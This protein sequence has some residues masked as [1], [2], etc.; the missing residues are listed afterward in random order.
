[1][2]MLFKHFGP[3]VTW[4]VWATFFLRYIDPLKVIWGDH[5]LWGP[6][7]LLNHLG[8][9]ENSDWFHKDFGDASGTTR[10]TMRTQR[11]CESCCMSNRTPSATSINFGLH[12]L[13]CSRE[14]HRLERWRI[15]QERVAQTNKPQ[16]FRNGWRQ[17]EFT[18]VQLQNAL[19]FPP[20]KKQ[21]E[22]YSRYLKVKGQ[23]IYVCKN[24]PENQQFVRLSSSL[25]S[26]FGDGLI[27]NT[28]WKPD[29]GSQEDF[30][31][32]WSP[33]SSLASSCQ[34]PDFY[35]HVGLTVSTH[36]TGTPLDANGGLWLDPP[37]ELTLGS[38]SEL[39]CRELIYVDIKQT[40]DS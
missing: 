13:R 19:Q 29:P 7:T 6:C 8:M 36:P 20:R 23:T 4:M 38:W 32:I 1:M 39:G 33:Y 12:S 40:V 3:G 21:R 28:L 22:E 18:M 35:R 16:P 10:K 24:D 37:H 2:G 25:Q 30:T 34:T 5:N 31:D 11:S 15:F 17:V 9:W 26:S 14:V 27:K